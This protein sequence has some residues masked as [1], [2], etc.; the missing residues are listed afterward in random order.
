MKMKYTPAFPQTIDHENGMSLLDYFAGQAL[1]ALAAK[2]FE[3]EI[4]FDELAETCYYIAD[5]MMAGRGNG[6]NT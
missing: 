6:E 2:Y 1:L 4:G 3:D 5:A